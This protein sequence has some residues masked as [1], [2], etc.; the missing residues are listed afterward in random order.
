[1]KTRTHRAALWYA[2]HNWFVLPLHA[3]LFDDKKNLTGCTCEAWRRRKNPDYLCRTPGKHPIIKD[4]EENATTDIT[5]VNDWWQRW[6][7]ANVGIAAGKSGLLC[8]DLD[9]YKDSYQGDTLI[10]LGDEQTVTSITGSGG[11]H[12]IYEMPEGAAYTN[13][14]SQLPTGIDIRGFGGQFVAPPSVHPSGNLYQWESGYGPHEIAPLPVPD[15]LR[16][17]LDAQVITAMAAVNFV[18]DVEPPQL[19]HI[20]MK[21]EIVELIRNGAEKG[22]R[23]ENDQKVITALVAAG[24]TDDEIRAVF[25]HYAIGVRGKFA[26]KGEHALQYL[27]HSIAHARGWVSVKREEMIER[28]AEQAMMAM[29][30]R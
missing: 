3:P 19:E 10:S 16:E 17:I 20:H 1:M 12:L 22:T 23:S 24:A 27:A 25:S 2:E 30:I 6:P 13:A 4:W 7:W 29:V 28:R 26:E 5:T 14:H 15:R 21:A 9:S 11:T 18:A 8:F